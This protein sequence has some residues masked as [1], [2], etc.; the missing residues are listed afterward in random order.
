MALVLRMA[1][2]NPSWGHRRDRHHQLNGGDRFLEPDRLPRDFHLWK[3][4]KIA[5]YS[6]LL[7]P[8]S[9]TCASVHGSR[10]D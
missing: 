10:S 3:H 4:V 5:D 8:A 7:P 6:T 9:L 1:Q 2:E